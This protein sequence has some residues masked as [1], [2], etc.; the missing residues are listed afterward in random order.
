MIGNASD[1]HPLILPLRE[2]P[3]LAGKSQCRIVASSVYTDSYT[4]S[5]S[6]SFDPVTNVLTASKLPRGKVKLYFILARGGPALF[7]KVDIS[8]S[9][10][11]VSIRLHVSE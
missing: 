2:R 10:V 1:L 5:L 7:R 3:L 8:R 6:N 9:A 4:F 11:G